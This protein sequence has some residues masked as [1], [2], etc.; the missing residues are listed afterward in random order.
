MKKTSEKS[1]N[2]W[3]SFAHALK[4]LRVVFNEPN[5]KIHFVIAFLTIALG[6]FFNITREEWVE[7]FFAIALVIGSEA[8]NTAIEKVVDLVSP[9]WNETARQA[10]DAAAASVLI[11]S[12][13]AFAV[14]VAVFFPKIQNMVVG[15]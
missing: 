4:G 9:D 12:L 15:I 1:I 7:I 10:K 14:G 3:Q 6:L 2:R 5:A 8:L 11:F 13:C